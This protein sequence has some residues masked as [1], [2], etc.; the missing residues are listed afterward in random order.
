MIII[1]L[2]VLGLVFGSFVNA[3]VWR[4]R[5]QEL[6]AEASTDKNKAKPNDKKHTAD[7]Q[8]DYSIVHGR[9]MCPKC[10]HTLAPKDLV[11]VLSWLALK[12]K[13]RYCHKPISWQYPL[14]ELL[15]ALIFVVSYLLWPLEF[16]A[17]GV[18]R[19]AFWLI[20]MVF[21]MA[22]SVYDVHWFELPNRVVFP[23]MYL[24]GAQVLV[25][26]VWQEDAAI[27]W[28]SALG[29]ITIFGLFWVIYQVSKGEW[30]GGGDVK[31]GM[32]LGL[33]VGSPLYALLV[34]FIASLLGILASLPMLVSKRAARGLHV[35]F[36]PALILATVIVQLF[37]AALVAWYEGLL[38]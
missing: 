7:N 25:S 28:Q 10:H 35:Q 19:L 26:A 18:F 9:S 23:L 3:F 4:L 37:G 21:F 5:Q 8:E 14:V 2:C 31:L 12:G 34:I 6:Q 1:S 33:L 29:G 16:D 13:C 32:V 20:F 24:A 15:T 17:Y 22:L 36:G 38:V 11:P 27:I 30:I